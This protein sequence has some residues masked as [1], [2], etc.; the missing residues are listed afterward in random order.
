MF[1]THELKY[2]DSNKMESFFETVGGSSRKPRRPKDLLQE[3]VDDMKEATDPSRMKRVESMLHAL[4]LD[5][6]KDAIDEKRSSQKSRT[7]KQEVGNQVEDPEVP[8]FVGGRTRTRKPRKSDDAE[9]SRS[10]LFG[11]MG[12]A[13][14]EDKRKIRGQQ[15]SKIMA[16][17]KARGNP[18]SLAEA[19]SMLKGK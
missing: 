11:K 15:I 12:G 14:K 6:V 4:K 19:S 8:T 16:A 13:V 9:D 5:T 3:R 7:L 1:Q 17:A 2:S 18:I 10:L